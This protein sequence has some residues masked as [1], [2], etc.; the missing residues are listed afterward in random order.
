MIDWPAL[1]SRNVSDLGTPA[2]IVDLE[3]FERN[4]QKMASHCRASN[5]ALRPHA[6]THKSAKVAKR[7]IAAGAIGQCSAS[8]DE[9]EFLAG[10]GIASILI[11]AP[12]VSEPAIRRLLAL[13]AVCPELLAVA[14]SQ[15][16]VLRFS[17]AAS[18]AGQ[19]LRLLVDIDLG[20]HRTGVV[21]GQ[22]ACD[23]A[24]LVAQSPNLQFAGIQGYA[25]HLMHLS[26]RDER[27]V[28]S[29]AA[30]SQLRL[31]RDRLSDLGLSPRIIT[32]GG[33]G[34]FDIDPA[35]QVLTELQAGSYIFMDRQYN[36]VWAGGPP[37]ETSLFVLSTV[38][39]VNSP[40]IVTTDAGLKAFST[41][42]DMPLIAFGPGATYSFFGDEYGRVALAENGTA[43][44]GEAVAC[45]TPHCDPTV[46]LY[47][48]Y[49]V[50]HGDEIVDRW[51]IANSKYRQSAP[52]PL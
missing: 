37:F 24:R 34:S 4:I 45:I 39:S 17:L 29:A 47:G 20:H 43:K 16:A 33:T 1:L 12:I 31:T 7:Q 40:G 8:L 52:Y 21:P 49:L 6:K 15:Q 51:P 19:V 44:A 28:R 27:Q 18:N 22:P 9:A 14:D 48:H 3:A 23:L 41:D 38:V 42:A 10:A 32:G 25:G 13:N 46:N 50:V 11:T 36:E 30:L 26:D 2:L 35:E 5:I